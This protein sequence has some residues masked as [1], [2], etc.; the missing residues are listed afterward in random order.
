MNVTVPIQ[1]TVYWRSTGAY[2]EMRVFCD[3][4]LAGELRIRAEKFEAF[5]NSW[6]GARFIED[7]SPAA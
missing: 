4:P 3:G 2:V 1:I 5:R 7:W 6:A